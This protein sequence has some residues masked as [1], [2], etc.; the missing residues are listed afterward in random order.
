MFLQIG[1]LRLCPSAARTGFSALSECPGL[2]G[3]N[4]KRAFL[5]LLKVR[6]SHIQVL[7]GSTGDSGLLSGV[8]VAALEAPSLFMGALPS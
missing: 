5:T 2:G 7:A 1:K 3:S 6:G 4:G 8:R